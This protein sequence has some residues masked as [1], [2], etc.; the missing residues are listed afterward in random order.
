MQVVIP[1]ILQALLPAGEKRREVIMKKKV[2]FQRFSLV[3]ILIIWVC[4]IPHFF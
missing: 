1:T 2:V 4:H 3:N